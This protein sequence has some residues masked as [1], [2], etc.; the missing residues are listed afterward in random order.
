LTLDYEG[1]LNHHQ[2]VSI[3]DYKGDCRKTHGGH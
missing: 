3:L 2:M 1:A